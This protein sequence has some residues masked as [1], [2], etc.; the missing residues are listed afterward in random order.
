MSAR[1]RTRMSQFKTRA[2]A[3]HSSCDNGL[4]VFFFLD[5]WGG[6]LAF[7]REGGAR[8]LSLESCQCLHLPCLSLGS[9]CRLAT[10]RSQKG[11]SARLGAVGSPSHV[12]AS[13]WPCSAGLKPTDRKT[14]APP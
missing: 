12:V 2:I 1:A 6:G 13:Q 4:W 11:G 3:H 14:G 9:R 8:N 5:G 7:C 10:G